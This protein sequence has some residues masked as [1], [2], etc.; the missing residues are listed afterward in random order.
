MTG[1]AATIDKLRKGKI[2]VSNG[3][4]ESQLQEMLDVATDVDWTKPET[5]R[6]LYNTYSRLTGEQYDE[7]I[8]ARMK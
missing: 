6:L 1:L 5:V 3:I 2:P 8:F 7:S 4:G